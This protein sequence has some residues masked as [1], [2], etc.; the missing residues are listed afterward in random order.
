MDEYMFVFFFHF[1][2]QIEEDLAHRLL[3]LLGEVRV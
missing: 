2:F 3:R 1:I